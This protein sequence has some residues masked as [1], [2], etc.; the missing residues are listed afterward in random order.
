MEK[1]V[2][3]VPWLRFWKVIHGDHEYFLLYSTKEEAVKLARLVS[4]KRHE[5]LIIVE[6]EKKK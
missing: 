6:K 3:V 2:Y 5:R 4:E 1:C